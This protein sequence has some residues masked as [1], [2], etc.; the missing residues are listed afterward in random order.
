MLGSFH[1]YPKKYTPNTLIIIFGPLVF[2][3]FFS[4]AVNIG[5]VGYLIS[6]LVFLVLV[7]AIVFNERHNNEVL[8]EALCENGKKKTELE[9]IK[10]RQKLFLLSCRKIWFRLGWA[11]TLI[12]LSN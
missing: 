3:F 5:R 4:R 12:G 10:I 11:V 8:F 6:Y 7:F 1:R 2:L 9:E